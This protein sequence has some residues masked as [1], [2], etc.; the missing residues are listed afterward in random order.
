M[1]ASFHYIDVWSS[2]Y[3]WGRHGSGGPLPQEGQIVVVPE[4]ETL[5]LDI[6]TPKLKMLLIDGECLISTLLCS[7]HFY[8]ADL[9]RVSVG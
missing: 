6:N 8:F 2:R 3:T 9:T 1:D 5:L 7:P 4:N